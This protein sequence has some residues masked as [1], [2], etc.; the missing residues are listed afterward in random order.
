M[1]VVVDDP[2]I[3]WFS[4]SPQQPRS[5]KLLCFTNRGRLGN[6]MFQFSAVYSLS[7]LYGRHL[8]IDADMAKELETLFIMKLAENSAPYTVGSCGGMTKYENLKRGF[9]ED[10]LK[11]KD[12]RN[13]Q[14][15]G[16]FESWKYFY[17]DMKEILT[18]FTLTERYKKKCAQILSNVCSANVTCVAIHVRRGDIRRQQK[19]APWSYFQRAMRYYKQRFHKLHFFVAT[20]QIGWSRFHFQN[21]SDVTI[22]SGNAYDDLALLGSCDHSIMSVGTYSWWAAMMTQGTV[23]YYADRHKVLPDFFPPHWIPM[24]D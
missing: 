20:N 4:R 9:Q 11:I 10:F 6:K 3:Q 13:F 12:K 14:L 15:D 22:M 2:A 17:H 16:Y 18:L 21:T 1:S 19:E 24:T 5:T 7:K 23:V 8:V